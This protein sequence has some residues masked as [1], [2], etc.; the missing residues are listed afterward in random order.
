MA[1][2]TQ[3]SHLQGTVS[4][5]PI[6]VTFYIDY[7]LI[8]VQCILHLW[9]DQKAL[10]AGTYRDLVELELEDEEEDTDHIAKVSK[11]YDMRKEKVSFNI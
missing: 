11:V 9:A 4:N 2:T 1:F 7:L 3:L 5:L 10:D 8:L 6:F